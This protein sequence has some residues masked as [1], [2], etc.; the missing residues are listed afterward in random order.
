M[1]TPITSVFNDGYIAELYEQFRRDPSSLDESWR[2]FFRFAESLGG[3]AGGGAAGVADGE[4]LRKAAGAASLVSAIREHGH[5]AVPIDPL[6]SSPPGAA[7]LTPEF[8]GISE[9]DLAQVPRAALANLVTEAVPGSTAAEVV[10]SLRATYCDTIGF[11]FEHLDEQD[12]RAWFRGV[13]EQGE[14]TQPLTPEEKKAL[15]QR[16]T[17]VDGFERFLGL[18]FVN[19]KRFSIEGLD[20]LVPVLDEAIARAAAAGARRAVIGMAHRGR[21]NVLTH[22]LGKPAGKIFQEF[23]G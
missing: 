4:L 16:L 14:M 20:A 6:G 22:V 18:A 8:H 15:L 12:E 11:E 9:G 13:V 2:Q 7:E 5:L 17:Q 1:T 10:Q 21:L 23:A 3:V 19:A